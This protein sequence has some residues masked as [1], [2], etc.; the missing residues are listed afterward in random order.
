MF[1][2]YTLRTG[3]SVFALSALALIIAPGYFV[4][5]LGLEESA[6]LTW[7]MVLIGVTLVALAGNMAVVSFVAS[8][9]G[10]QI[11]SM[12]MMVAAG[13]LGEIA[14]VPLMFR[15]GPATVPATL[16]AANASALAA[17]LLLARSL[18]P[19]AETHEFELVAR[20]DADDL[21]DVKDVIL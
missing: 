13:G 12:V 15:L 11:A 5:L 4:D 14:L 18:R 6:A 21:S 19:A 17:F 1:L 20:T 9:R 7:S 3:A 16:A 10:V 8:D 2:R